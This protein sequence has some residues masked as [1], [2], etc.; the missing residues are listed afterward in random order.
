MSFVASGVV[1]I[2]F[3][4]LDVKNQWRNAETGSCHSATIKSSAKQH[5]LHLYMNRCSYVCVKIGSEI[6][7]LDPFHSFA[8]R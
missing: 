7:S 8:A 6:L 3:Y 2:A 1:V 4:A 5:I